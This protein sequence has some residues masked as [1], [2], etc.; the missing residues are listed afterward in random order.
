VEAEELQEELENDSELKD[1]L[2]ESKTLLKLQKLSTDA[3]TSIDC[4]ISTVARYSRESSPSFTIHRIPV[5]MIRANN[6]GKSTSDP[7]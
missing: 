1:L 7:T 4:D 6:C 5:A 2:D 3:T